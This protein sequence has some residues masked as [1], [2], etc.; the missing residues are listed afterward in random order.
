MTKETMSVHRALAEKK[1]LI[2]RLYK[3]LEDVPFVTRSTKGASVI[4][5]I[6]K[7]EYID[8]MTAHWQQIVDLIRR[9]NAICDAIQESNATTIVKIGD[10]ECTVARAI[11]MKDTDMTFKKRVRDVLVKQYE[12]AQVQVA[13]LNNTLETRCNQHIMSVYGNSTMDPNYA[14][15]VEETRKNY[16]ERETAVLV[17]PIDIQKQIVA[18]SNE[19]DAFEA[20]VDA[21]LSESNAVTVIEVVY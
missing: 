12:Q 15:Q 8:T 19:I 1:T 3:L 14:A 6:K 20:E 17:D 18:L 2:S 16:I 11:A 9:Y 21:V 13:N 4:N 7:G 10:I 5:G